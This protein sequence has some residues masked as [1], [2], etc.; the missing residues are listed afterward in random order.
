MIELE[1]TCQSLMFVDML[2]EARITSMVVSLLEIA[3]VT[4]V[5]SLTLLRFSGFVDF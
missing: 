1:E 4:N 2:I 3:N 5:R